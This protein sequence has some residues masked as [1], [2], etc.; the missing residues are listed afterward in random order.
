MTQIKKTIIGGVSVAVSLLLAA[1]SP[2]KSTPMTSYALNDDS[3]DALMSHG[4]HPEVLYV[5]PIQAASN[6]NTRS[7]LYMTQPYRVSSF[8]EHQWVAP[9]AQ[10]LLPRLVA[11]ITRRHYFHAVVSGSVPAHAAYQ[12]STRLLTWNEAF[13]YPKPLV[14]I[15]LSATLVNEKTHAV[16][17]SRRFA[18]SRDVVGKGPYAA[19]I[20]TNAAV[21]TLEEK[22]ARFV[23]QSLR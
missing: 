18:I 23:V 22:L 10:M 14:R 4:S 19:V 1:C 9:P 7:M 5:A 8:S 13:Y 2:V 21:D 15:T 16:I 17:A 3:S 12:L 11:G 6:L 20:A